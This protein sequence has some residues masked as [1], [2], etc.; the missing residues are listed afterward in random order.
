MKKNCLRFL[1]V[2]VAVVVCGQSAF[3]RQLS[4]NEALTRALK[5]EQSA[6]AGLRKAR[7]I[8][9]QTNVRT[10]PTKDNTATAFYVFE[11]AAADGFVVASADDRLQPVLGVAE[12]GSFSEIPENMQW[13]INQY[14]EEISAYYD[15][16][17]TDGEASEYTSLYDLYDSWAPIEPICKTYWNQTSPY[18]ALCPTVG[19]S[20]TPTGCVAT[21]LAQAI[22]A[23][24]Y[25]NPKGTK[26]YSNSNLGWTVSFDYNNYKPDFSKMRDKYDGNATQEE[27]DEVA[28]LMFACG[29][30]VE[31]NYNKGAT[32]TNFKLDAIEQYL[33][34]TNESFTVHRDGMSTTEWERIIYTILQAGKPICYGGSGSG[35]HAFICDGYSEDGFFHFNWGWSGSGNGYFRLSS[36]NPSHV[37]TGGFEGGYT[38]SQNILVLMTPDDDKIDLKSRPGSVV[39]NYSK[40]LNYQGGS[41]TRHTFGITYE[42]WYPSAIE[43]GI[44]LLLISRDAA[45]EKIYVAPS[46]YNML[47]SRTVYYNFS[48]NIPDGT[49]KEGVTYDAYPVYSFKGYEDMGYWFITTRQD[50]PTAKQDHYVISLNPKGE[51]DVLA[52]DVDPLK[53]MVSGVEINDFYINDEQNYFKCLLTNYSETSDYQ[54]TVELRLLKQDGT[55]VSTLATSYLLL[56]AGETMTLDATL[57]L[58]GQAAGK[59][60]L[61]LYRK[62]LDTPLTSKPVASF[63]LKSGTR[64]YEK[65]PGSQSFFEVALWANGKN[66]PL[67]PV[68]FL[69]GDEF[70]GVTS[71]QAFNSAQAQYFLA[72]FKHGET[73]GA[74]TKFPIF[75]GAIKGSGSWIEGEKFSV[76][77]D[78]AIG[79][80]TMA[81]IDQYGSLVSAPV[82]FLVGTA[83]DGIIY[84][85][86]V[87]AKGLVVAGAQGAC[88]AKVTIP[89]EVEGYQVVG[90]APGAF[91]RCS[92]LEEVS[93]PAPI[94]SIGLHAF[95]ATSSLK[96]V[97][98][99]SKDVPFANAA[100][101]FASV[102]P[103][104]EFYVAADAFDAYKEVFTYSGHL[105]ASI[106]ELK[107]PAEAVA[108]KGVKSQIPLEVTP[109]ANYNPN[110]TVAVADESILTAEVVSGKIVVTPKAEGATTVTVSSAQPGV[111]PASTTVKVEAAPELP[112]EMTIS[113]ALIE[114]KEGTTVVLTAE[115]KNAPEGAI[116]VWASSDETVATVDS[117]G[118]VTGV[119]AGEAEITASFGDASASCTVKVSPAFGLTLNATSVNLK[120][121]ETKLLWYNF[122]GDAPKDVEVVWSTTD[123]SVA[124]VS[125][126][127]L[128]TAV[129]GGSAKIVATCGKVTAECLVTVEE[130]T[131]APVVPE[132]SIKLN[133]SKIELT[134]GETKI[135][136][137]EFE[138][139]A[140]KDAE[141]VW[142]SSDPTVARV[143][144]GLV[145]AVSAGEAVITLACEDK[146]AECKVTVKGKTSGGDE[147]PEKP[148]EDPEK[149]GD[150][151]SIV[152]VEADSSARYFDLSGRRIASP[153][154]VCIELKAGKARKVLVK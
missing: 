81:F 139:D 148:G 88:P 37:G 126:S 106:S 116:I 127:G 122:T 57:P 42:L 92:K 51:L 153:R 19:G 133:D 114:I 79:A 49:I 50:T 64:P 24:G 17:G 152:S 142:T 62:G 66:Q 46:G 124:T 54:D 18:N 29:V 5:S 69:A 110:F 91:D 149:P 83:K 118:Q 53:V 112:V 87:D 75:D 115:A 78:L 147:D 119:G 151:D 82:D 30:A 140:P 63:E 34:F 65:V 125:A 4:A 105:Y 138:G 56:S 67:A 98:F 59:Y 130:D 58:K 73:Y 94:K 80:Y 107:L 12:S 52:G 23:I 113:K 97:W 134:E 31:S 76:K 74:L 28:K 21:C 100:I 71:V 111:T 35:G 123:A 38:H 99:D 60:E 96:R 72:F 11:G 16:N 61:W 41:G 1:A 145:T 95:R 90:V 25:L 101:G 143:E 121:G 48:V 7:S 26:S 70:S 131:P 13:W 84:N 136:G 33:G 9:Q 27:R 120:V 135:L 154:G 2:G 68:S 109:A 93:L 10:F 146:K 15:A 132:Y 89:A 129:K 108:M 104:V 44:G 150:E 144:N 40:G 8:A 14:Q 43:T 36:L 32:G 47:R 45:K 77:P 117:K 85:Y 128:V 22:K 3:A 103:N 55:Q 141:L 137:Y 6:P 39:A 102:N 20:K 86:D